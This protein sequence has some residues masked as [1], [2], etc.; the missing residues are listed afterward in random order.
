M[1]IKKKRKLKLGT[2]F[3]KDVKQA[4]R[5]GKRITKQKVPKVRKK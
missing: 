3:A 2:G 5:V 1:V 4:L